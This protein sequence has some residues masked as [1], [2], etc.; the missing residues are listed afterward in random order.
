[1]EVK[2][3]SLLEH[4]SLMNTNVHEPIPNNLFE[5]RYGF[6]SVRLLVEQSH[7]ISLPI[8]AETKRWSAIDVFST[9]VEPVVLQRHLPSGLYAVVPTS[10]LALRSYIEAT[11][12]AVALKLFIFPA[13]TIGPVYQG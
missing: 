5:S 3:V 7:G 6:H 8:I 11:T 4:P 9:G 1:M 13:L 12:N 10:L 2:Y